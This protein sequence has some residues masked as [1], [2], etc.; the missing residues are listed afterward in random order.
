MSTYRDI[1]NTEIAV[2]APLTQQLMQALK[3]NV[4]AIQEGDATAVAQGKVIS[5]VSGALAARATT[6]SHTGG[7]FIEDRSQSG[8]VTEQNY[9][10]NATGGTSLTNALAPISFGR[11]GT[12]L[13]HM[14]ADIHAVT[15]TPTVS[16]I[17]EIDTGSGYATVSE[18]T[19]SDKALD[20]AFTSLTKVVSVTAGDLIRTRLLMSGSNLDAIDH[21]VKL[22]AYVDN[23]LE[24]L[25]YTRRIVGFTSASAFGESAVEYIPNGGRQSGLGTW[26]AP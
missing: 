13:I 7:F 9:D 18:L 4:L 12:Y 3:D 2:D 11:D 14:G 16:Y 26:S 20:S 23:P 15:G 21:H 17:T 25:G 8:R 1:N 6:G 19:V 22:R 10:D 24:H 5:T